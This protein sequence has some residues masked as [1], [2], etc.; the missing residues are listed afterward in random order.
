MFQIE[1]KEDQNKLWEAV[2][3]SNP[4]EIRRLLSCGLLDV[5]Y[6]YDDYR[7]CSTLL[8]AAA[9]YTHKDVVQ[10][11]LDKGAEYDRTN[12]WGETPLNVAAL[13]VRID[14]VKVLLDAGADP[15]IA[16][17]DGTT[18]LERAISRTGCWEMVKLLTSRGAI[19]NYQK[20]Q[21]FPF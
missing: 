5:N 14:V 4:D 12:R 10:L 16:N 19:I 21:K 1:I 7:H 9:G 2:R 11:L 13:C 8:L 17:E 18:P 20:Y 6:W 3:D 15:N